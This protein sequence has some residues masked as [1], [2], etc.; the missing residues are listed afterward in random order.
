MIKKLTAIFFTHTLRWLGGW[1]NGSNNTHQ[2]LVSR[3]LTI[4][5]NEKSTAY[6]FFGST[7]QE[8]LLSGSDWP[9]EHEKDGKTLN[10]FHFYYWPDKS[11]YWGNKTDHA[12]ARFLAWY[13]A[14]VDDWK[15]G[16]T[17]AGVFSLGKAIHYF[18]DLYTPV[19]TA[20]RCYAINIPDLVTNHLNFEKAA[21]SG[22]SAFAVST[23]GLYSGYQ[24]YTLPYIVDVIAC[25]SYN[26]Y[27]NASTAYGWALY[28]NQK[29]LAGLLYK[30][31]LDI[32]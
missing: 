25:A 32:K 10:E 27:I 19:H 17:Y 31:Y 26:S 6:N 29:D 13:K 23:G 1:S 9:D 7:E 5:Q 15:D 12:K 20:Q 21:N 30:F 8:L 18:C 3:A 24:N 4:L 16:K 22:K 14:A 2:W 11:S 28:S